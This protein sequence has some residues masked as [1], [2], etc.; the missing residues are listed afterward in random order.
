VETLIMNAL[1]SKRV[2]GLASMNAVVV[3]DGGGTK[4]EDSVHRLAG[5]PSH[6]RLRTSLNS[7][8]INAEIAAAPPGTFNLAGA[9]PDSAE[10]NAV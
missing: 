7:E 3:S 1:V 9:P 4:R 2:P 6:R 8:E 10:Q 5:R